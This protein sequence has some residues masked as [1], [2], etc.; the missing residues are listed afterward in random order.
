VDAGPT[1][2]SMAGGTLAYAGSAG[3]NKVFTDSLIPEVKNVPLTFP[4]SA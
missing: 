3:G 4:W 1:G 2:K